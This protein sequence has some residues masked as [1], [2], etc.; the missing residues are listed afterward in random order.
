MANIDSLSNN[1]QESEIRNQG[2]EYF[3]REFQDLL[4]EL[5]CNQV[6]VFNVKSAVIEKYMEMRR[7]GFSEYINLSELEN[8]STN[9][10]I[11]EINE[12][13]KEYIKKII[14]KIE[15]NID[16]SVKESLNYE[17]NRFEKIYGPEW[18]YIVS[19]ES[20]LI[21]YLLQILE[22]GIKKEKCLEMI[23]DS[24]AKYKN[25]YYKLISDPIKISKKN[26]ESYFHVLMEILKI[27]KNTGHNEVEL[28]NTKGFFSRSLD[29][30]MR[31]ISSVIEKLN[32][33]RHLELLSQDKTIS[34]SERDIIKN[35]YMEQKKVLSD[36]LILSSQIGEYH[37]NGQS[38]TEEVTLDLG[39][40]T[41][42]FLDPSNKIQKD[43]T[44][45]EVNS[46][47]SNKIVWRVILKFKKNIKVL[48]Q[49]FHELAV[50]VKELYCSPSSK[51]E[52]WFRI[53]MVLTVF[54]GLFAS[55]IAFVFFSA[56]ES[57]FY[58][59]PILKVPVVLAFYW[60]SAKVS[61]EIFNWTDAWY[62]AYERWIYGIEGHVEYILTEK[63]K[64]YFR[65]IELQEM[66]NYFVKEISTYQ[67]RLNK[68]KD[69][70]SDAFNIESNV[71]KQLGVAWQIIQSGGI[72]RDRVKTVKAI[73]FC[74]REI[75]KIRSSAY[76][77]QF[78]RYDDGNAYNVLGVFMQN[79]R[80]AETEDSAKID[81]NTK[82]K[83]PK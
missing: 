10:K 22:N 72:G 42:S 51:G 18:M 78:W 61:S 30:K 83:S 8:L 7:S 67:R 50:G 29:E 11:I 33:I 62:R 1:L 75:Y 66:R 13:K 56:K 52:K 36:F 43:D 23:N 17:V 63:A 35:F 44:V 9:T 15:K 53:G 24:S 57:L 4:K 69:K 70:E 54:V 58:E 47:D 46:N 19:N 55:L 14:K 20:E 28:R 74:L 45:I 40:S 26:A 39:Y 68:I 41:V 71:I 64:S 2:E 34:L 80:H 16:S 77:N 76:R 32:R 12:I 82:F 73:Q 31:F 25:E 48:S 59:D 5:D 49:P 6:E 21:Y 3:N 60:A 81:Q 37:T 79:L 27:N 65:E 38:N